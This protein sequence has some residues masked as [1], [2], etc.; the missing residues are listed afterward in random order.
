MWQEP[1]VGSF[2]AQ[3]FS[4]AVLYCAQLAQP[5]IDYLTPAGQRRH[6][7]A[8][9]RKRLR[10]AQNPPFGQQPHLLDHSSLSKHADALALQDTIAGMESANRIVESLSWRVHPHVGVIVATRSVRCVED[11]R[12]KG[13]VIPV[14]TF[15]LGV[16]H[17]LKI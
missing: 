16:L 12:A 9:S 15:F 3:R 17:P 6:F 5:S 8:V 11:E 10:V 14:V 1:A 7:H 4:Y 13:E 2:Y